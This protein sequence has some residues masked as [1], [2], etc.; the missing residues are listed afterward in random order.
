MKSK[1]PQINFFLLLFFISSTFLGRTIDAAPALL[2]EL[3]STDD[4]AKNQSP[5]LSQDGR[6]VVFQSDDQIVKKDTKTGLLQLVSVTASGEAG[7]KASFNPQVSA[8][9]RFV[10]F[11]SLSTN[12]ENGASSEQIYLKDTETGKLTLVSKSEPGTPGNFYS[13]FSILSSDSNFAYFQG[14][15]S[16]LIAGGDRLYRIYSKNL[17]TQEVR[18]ISSSS[19][20]TPANAASLHVAVEPSHQFILFESSSTNLAD[21][22]SGYQLYRK[23]LSTGEVILVSSDSKNVAAA[24]NSGQ[25]RMT[26][27][28]RFVVF[29][30]NATNFAKDVKGTQIY[31][32][33][34]STGE[35]ILIS[36]DQAGVSGNGFNSFP[37]VSDDGSK[38][39][40]LSGSTY[41]KN[42]GAP[43]SAH[44]YQKNISTG[45]LSIIRTH[46]FDSPD[47]TIVA[48]FDVNGAANTLVFSQQSK[49]KSQIFKISN[50]NN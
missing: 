46:F 31:R 18:M 43:G 29:A 40:F 26:P 3:I 38:V 45:E 16:N 4:H 9:A 41:W 17:S 49:S 23:N 35:L 1:K 12:F 14:N 47:S 19:N 5:V 36:V 21:V 27:G 22:K 20:G 15:S 2:Q 48:T 7:N 37:H 8:D 42:S 6:Y 44:L 25:G 10:T 33:D 34:L 50:F 13:N 30:S 28:G 24:G 39:I 32:K 11:E